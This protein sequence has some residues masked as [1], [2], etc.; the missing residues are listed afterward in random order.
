V[1]CYRLV[2]PRCGRS[3][4]AKRNSVYQIKYCRVCTQQGRLRRRAL[5]Q[6]RD[7]ERTGGRRRLPPHE[8]DRA[9]EI[10]LGGQSKAAAAREVGVTPSAVTKMFKRRS[11]R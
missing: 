4:Y 2:C 8:Q 11:R 10:V 6:Y 7:R 5:E 3:R 9:I 1:Y